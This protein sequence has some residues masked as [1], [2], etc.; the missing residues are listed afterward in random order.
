M[1]SNIDRLNDYKNYRTGGRARKLNERTGLERRT[2]L[3]DTVS[4]EKMESFIIE[5]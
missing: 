5:S 3:L 1:E 4:L 2:S